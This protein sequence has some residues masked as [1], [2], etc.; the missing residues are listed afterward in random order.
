M[1][2]LAEDQ[3][4]TRTVML[5]RAFSLPRT[6]RD[7]AVAV[8]DVAGLMFDAPPTT[9]VVSRIRRTELPKATGLLYVLYLLVGKECLG[10]S[11]NVI[12]GR[13]EERGTFFG[14]SMGFHSITMLLM[15]SSLTE[16]RRKF[17]AFSKTTFEY[18]DLLTYTKTGS[19]LIMASQAFQNSLLS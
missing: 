13:A 2:Q 6:G 18:A 16:K 14:V 4:T 10:T 11:T 19:C 8:Q 7:T 9:P 5:R 17:S 15:P 12:Q 1:I 3:G